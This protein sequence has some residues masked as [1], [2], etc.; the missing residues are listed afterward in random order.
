MIVSY[1]PQHCVNNSNL[2]FYISIANTCFYSFDTALTI[3]D[4]LRDAD[5]TLNFIGFNISG[6]EIFNFYGKLKIFFDTMILYLDLNKF[7]SDEK[8]ECITLFHDV[9]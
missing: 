4:K 9:T 6:R 8:N 3:P 7:S 1:Y 5:S 2:N